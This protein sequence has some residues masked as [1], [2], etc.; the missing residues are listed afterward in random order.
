M[1]HKEINILVVVALLALASCHNVIGV[2]AQTLQKVPQ[3]ASVLPQLNVSALAKPLTYKIE[4]YRSEAMEGNRT[5]GIS[6]PPGYEENPNQRYPVIL[7]LHGGHGDPDDWFKEKKGNA[8]TTL[9]QLYTTGKL[10]PSIIITPDGNDRRGSSPYWD[11]AYID[12]PHGQVST[13]VGDELV[14]VVKD[15][16]RTLPTPNF[17]AIGGLSS[18]GWGAVN[19]GLHNLNHFSILFSHSGYF[20]DKSGPQNSPISYIKSIPPEARKR[21][22]VYLDSG[23]SDEELEESQKFSQVLS[24]EKIYNVFRQFPGSH[25]WSYWRKHLADSLTFVGEQFKILEIQHAADNLGSSKP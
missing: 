23:K 5:Y 19:V 21:L 22:R 20:R 24:Q 17:W 3:T 18:G 7:L 11:P 9:Q 1:N 4:T 8:L 14:K 6:L 15:R 13:A 2:R 16:Y 12:G 25:T 10:P